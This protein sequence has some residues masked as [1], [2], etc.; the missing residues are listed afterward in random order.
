ML[1]VDPLVRKVSERPETGGKTA[2]AELT[3]RRKDGELTRFQDNCRVVRDEH[4]R[5]LH[6]EGTLTDITA[7]RTPS[8]S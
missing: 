5:V 4:G 3:L 1:Y 2:N 6:Y 7:A 8:S